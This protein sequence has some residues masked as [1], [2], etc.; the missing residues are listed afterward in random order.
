M[1]ALYT[2]LTKDVATIMN[3]SVAK[4]LQLEKEMEEWDKMYHKELKSVTDEH[5]KMQASGSTL[6]A[7]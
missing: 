7:S 5:T 2:S 6:I 3:D 4:E 1:T